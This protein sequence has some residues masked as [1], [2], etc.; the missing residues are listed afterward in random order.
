[1]KKGK[2]VTFTLKLVRPDSKDTIKGLP[3]ALQK[4][5]KSGGSWS[6]IKSGKTGAN[7]TKTFTLTIKKTAKYRTLGKVV[8]Q[9]NGDGRAIAKVTSKAV[10]VKVK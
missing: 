7:G 4:A 2:K 3:I 6:T 8:K 5:P 10:T 9:K 1:M